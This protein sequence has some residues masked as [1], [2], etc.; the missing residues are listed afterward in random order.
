M[1]ILHKSIPYLV[2]KSSYNTDYNNPFERDVT[3]ELGIFKKPIY[4]KKKNFLIS[5]Y[6]PSTNFSGL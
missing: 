4:D 5:T 1:E 3:I 6:H 2:E